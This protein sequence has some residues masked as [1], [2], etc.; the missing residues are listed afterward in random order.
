M[1]WCGSVYAITSLLS[2]NITL[3][4]Y[5]TSHLGFCGWD[6]L[7]LHNIEIQPER[8]SVCTFHISRRKNKKITPISIYISSSIPPVRRPEVVTP[9][10]YPSFLLT[11]PSRHTLSPLGSV[12][13]LREGFFASILH[14]Q[15][16]AMVILQ[17]GSIYRS[18]SM[19][20]V[21]SCNFR[22]LRVAF[23][24]WKRL[25][26]FVDMQVY[27]YAHK[28]INTSDSN[29]S[30]GCFALKHFLFSLLVYSEKEN[31]DTHRADQAAICSVGWTTLFD[32]TRK[33]ES[34]QK[35]GN[36]NPHFSQENSSPLARDP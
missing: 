14:G 18:E 2:T 27:K 8:R 11:S 21:R 25:D 32:C 4:L 5:L 31:T 26:F 10:I 9:Q 30:A 7:C 13:Y 35:W 34:C 20:E 29:L 28:R 12:S 33:L 3:G 36:E 24:H 1:P 16:P 6:E 19:V 17:I 15:T 23:H 22:F